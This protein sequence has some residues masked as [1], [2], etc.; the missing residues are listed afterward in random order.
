MATITEIWTPYALDS[1]DDWTATTTGSTPDP[2]ES[3]NYV[4]DDDRNPDTP[5]T[6]PPETYVDTGV[7]NDNSVQ[8]FRLRKHS[9]R[10]SVVSEITSINV[11][12][13]CEAID[14]GTGDTS[15]DVYLVFN[16]SES[17][18]GSVNQTA[19]VR[20]WKTISDTTGYGSYSISDLRVR[21][22]T[23]SQGAGDQMRIYVVY[24]E[25]VGYSSGE[26]TKIVRPTA[27]GSVINL[28]T[29]GSST[30]YLNVDDSVTQPTTTTD[31]NYNYGDQDNDDDIDEYIIGSDGS[32]G[33][34]INYS[35]RV[36]VW[37]LCNDVESNGFS[38]RGNLKIGGS[39]QG[40]QTS[41]Y[42]QGS[43]GWVQL[44][45]RGNWYSDDFDDLQTRIQMPASL[46][47]SD[48]VQI[49]AVYCEIYYYP[50]Q[51]S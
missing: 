42:P 30:H 5:S 14:G 17:L 2:D 20:S 34:N 4:N 21:F 13:Y 12:F 36:D 41:S 32:N 8:G 48:E 50:K 33:R 49:E 19:G 23:A 15:V 10:P 7:N 24:V 45:F 40:E 29:Q 38:L 11:Y 22:D 27:E 37:Y 9:G 25:V 18:I 39:W 1:D 35:G 43:F 47:G 3:W 6:D 44:T 31:S 28:Q 26:F 51:V 16:G 46:S